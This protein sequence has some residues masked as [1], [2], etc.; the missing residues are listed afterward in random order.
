MG[1]LLPCP[2]PRRRN[3]EPK[4]QPSSN[5]L[6]SELS[7][8]SLS[9]Q[10]SLP[11]V[12][13]LA[14]SSSFRKQ[15]PAAS[16]H[17]CS[18]TLKVKGNSSYISSLAIAG[19]LLYSGSSNGEIRAW[20]RDPN[21]Y[22]NVTSTD[23]GDHA[24]VVATGNGDAVKSLVVLGDKL[25]SAHQDHKIRVWKIDNNTSAYYSTSGKLKNK[26][27]ERIAT[28][29][30][31]N[32][33]FTKCFLANNYVQVRRHK[34]CT[35][36]HHVD[37]VSALALSSDGSLL[38]STSWDRTFKI[39]RTS[40]FR[41]LESVK[42]AHDDAIN[43]IVVSKSNDGFVYTGSADTKIKVWKKL[44]AA[45]QV[46]KKHSLVQTLEKHKSAVTALALSTDGTVLYSGACDR[47]I[48]VWERDQGNYIVDGDDDSGHMVLKGALRGHTKAILCL[49]VV[50]NL[51][52]SGSSDNTIRIWRRSSSVTDHQKGYSCL[53]VLE[54]HRRPVKCLTAVVDSDYS[55]RNSDH[56]STSFLVYSGSL[57]CEIKIWQIRVP[58]L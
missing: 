32:D 1:L 10:P 9:S 35:W 30:T 22:V 54:G 8:A 46:N 38:Y 16:E 48:L 19:K 4:F 39:W 14:P 45:L 52:F 27:Y 33:R 41:C 57:D 18:A 12:P 25:F 37:T 13:S 50:S 7:N 49:A 26:Y 20:N 44:R 47:S 34:K 56:S 24:N 2:M 23:V 28:L 5:H 29:P 6:Q 40:D 17:Q 21:N 31:L 3:K 15:A 43:A 53:A 36:V 42:N 51:L 55:N 11:S 58:F